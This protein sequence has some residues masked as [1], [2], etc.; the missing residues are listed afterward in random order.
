MK[1]KCPLSK[2]KGA[3]QLC[4]NCTADLHLCFCIGDNL[5]FSL[6]G[7]YVGRI[8]PTSNQ[9]ESGEFVCDRANTPGIHRLP[10]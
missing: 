1:K 6:C 2:T 9:M 4:S 8:V 10:V 7:S 3:D 5:V